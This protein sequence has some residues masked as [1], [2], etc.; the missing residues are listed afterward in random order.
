MEF[1][2]G[3]YVQLESREYKGRDSVM[4]A[5]SISSPPSGRNQVELMIRLVPNGI[6]TTWV[7]EYL[8]E[9]ETIDLSGPYGEFRLSDTEAPILFV[10]GGSGMAPIWSMLRD[11]EGKGIRRN[12]KYFFGALTQRDLFLV[13]ELTEMEKRNDWFTF[14]PALSNEPGDSGWRGER[15]LI[16]QVLKRHVPDAS[17]CEAYLC[18]SPGMIDACIKVLKE[19]GMPENRISYDKFS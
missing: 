6:C 4:R 12:A 17:A 14:V 19:N 18:G 10:A 15:G 1:V 16:T 13:E 11:M 5:Y 9:G 7:F 8:K 2:A 3:Q